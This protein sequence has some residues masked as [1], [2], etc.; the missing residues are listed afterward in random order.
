[1][2][3]IEWIRLH[4]REYRRRSKWSFLW[5]ISVEG[6]LVSTAVA[7]PLYFLFPF[8]PRHDLDAGLGGFLWLVVLTPLLETLLLQSFPVMISRV[9]GA[10]FRW[11]LI[12]AWI[13]FAAVH[14]L[15]NIS[16]GICGG[17]VSGFYIGFTY[18]HWRAISLRPAFWMT[19]A[20]HALHNLVPGLLVL[21]TFK[22]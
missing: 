4:F 5:R 19:C 17:I 22:K 13:P 7:A 14:F 10:G 2:R 1:M 6:L 11:Q 8:T 3:V 15:V 20:H 18:A 9:F 21:M 12:A 16:V